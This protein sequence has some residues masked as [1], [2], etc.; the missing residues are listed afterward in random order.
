ML[1]DAKI[2]KDLAYFTCQG[3][4]EWKRES[5]APE[6]RTVFGSGIGLHFF[7]SAGKWFLDIS[8]AGHRNEVLRESDFSPEFADLANAVEKSCCRSALDVLRREIFSRYYMRN[9]RVK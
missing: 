1:D 2:L 7:K 9:R 5:E 8:A 4:L 3:V 6:Y